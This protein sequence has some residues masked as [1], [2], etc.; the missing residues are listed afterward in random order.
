MSTVGLY[1]IEEQRMTA[2]A[3]C[4]SRQ[5]RRSSMVLLSQSDLHFT[6]AH[7]Y[8]R[9]YYIGVQLKSGPLTKP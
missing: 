6:L 9:P 1:S 7:S 8:A 5:S 4:D 2:Q 3:S